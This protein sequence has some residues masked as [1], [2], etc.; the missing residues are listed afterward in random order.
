MS[1]TIDDLTE[2]DLDGNGVFDKLMQTVNLHIDDQYTKGRLKGSDYATVYLGALQTVIA[3]SIAFAL[4]KDKADKEVEVQEAQIA[5]YNRQREG[6]D[7]NKYQK[8]FESQMN[9]WGL[10]FSSGL[11]TEK[12]SIITSDKASD[13]YSKLTEDID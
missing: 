4:Q 13:L 12:P 10:M 8:L 1:T 2:V 11:L 7:D 9:A 5:L 6:F 3:Q